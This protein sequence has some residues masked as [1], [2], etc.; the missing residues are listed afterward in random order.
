[1]H[2]TPFHSTT[3]KNIYCCKWREVLK[4]EENFKTGTLSCEKDLADLMITASHKKFQF[5][6]VKHIFGINTMWTKLTTSSLLD[7]L[8]LCHY[9]PNITSCSALTVLTMLCWKVNFAATNARS[10][11]R[12]RRGS[13]PAVVVLSTLRH[14]SYALFRMTELPTECWKVNIPATDEHTPKRGN[15]TVL[16]R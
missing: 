13:W 10:E 2:V 11:L 7:A 1:M 14:P 16:V 5:C 9:Q 4:L 12:R 3:H 6:L 8:C 15:N